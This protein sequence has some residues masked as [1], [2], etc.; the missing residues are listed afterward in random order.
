MIP[1]GLSSDRQD[2][3]NMVVARAFSC[4]SRAGRK[5]GAEEGKSCGGLS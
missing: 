4:R 2:I 1:Q 5:V 3:F